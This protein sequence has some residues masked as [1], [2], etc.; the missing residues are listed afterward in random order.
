MSSWWMVWFGKIE[1]VQVERSTAHSVW[2]DGRKNARLTDWKSY[3]PTW[4]EAHA[5][6]LEKAERRLN[7]ARDELQLAQGQFG[8]VKGMKHP[9]VTAEPT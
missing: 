6:L 9:T 4:A 8:N 3:F 5:W 2:V 1:P 7:S